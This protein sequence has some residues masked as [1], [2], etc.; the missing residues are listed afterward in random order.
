MDCSNGFAPIGL[1]V[2]GMLYSVTMAAIFVIVYMAQ[3]VNSS[4]DT[5]TPGQRFWA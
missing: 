2:Y 1:S 4:P 5:G 3:S